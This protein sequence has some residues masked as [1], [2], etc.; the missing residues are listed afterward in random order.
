DPSSQETKQRP[1]RKVTMTFQ[2]NTLAAGDTAI[3]DKPSATRILANY[4]GG[5]WVPARAPGRLDVTNPANGEVLARVPL[6]GAADVEAA[7]AAAN[8][9]LPDWRGRSGGERTEFIFALC[10]KFRAR[11]DKMADSG[12]RE[13]GKV[14]SE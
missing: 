9:A 5:R 3:T 10:E 8:T 7:V 1:K 12:T 4:V 13:S 14:L 6:S 11:T 2:T